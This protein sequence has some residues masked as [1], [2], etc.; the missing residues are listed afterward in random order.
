MIS[1]TRWA[2]SARND[3]KPRCRYKEVKQIRRRQLVVQKP[4]I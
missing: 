1:R 4:M 2:Q 3:R